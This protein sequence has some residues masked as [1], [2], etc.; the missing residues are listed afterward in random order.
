MING[1]ERGTGTDLIRFAASRGEMKIPMAVVQEEL[2]VQNIIRIPND[3]YPNEAASGATVVRM[4]A[5]TVSL[6]RQS[7]D[8]ARSDLV[9]CSMQARKERQQIDKAV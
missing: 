2:S 9:D 4:A 1:Y 6:A 5:T 8:G 3:A 7:H